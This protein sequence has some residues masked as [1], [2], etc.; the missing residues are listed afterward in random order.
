MLRLLLVLLV[1]IS[2]IYGFSLFLAESY[3]NVAKVVFGIQL[4]SG[5]IS[6]GGSEDEYEESDGFQI[7]DG[8]VVIALAGILIMLFSLPYF[9]PIIETYGAK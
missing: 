1:F 6:A 3:L 2:A 5:V 4:I 8:H 7:R 9:F